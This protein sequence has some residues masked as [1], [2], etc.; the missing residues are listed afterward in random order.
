MELSHRQRRAMTILLGSDREVTLGVLAEA[1]DVSPRTVHR[2]LSRLGPALEPWGLTVRGRSGQGVQ[3]VG[4]PDRL[5]AFQEV[6]GG[7]PD[8]SLTAADR[9]WMAVTLLL[10]SS[11]SV[12]VFALEREL[13]VGTSAVR[14]ELDALE[15]WLAPFELALVRRRGFGVAVEGPE[16]QKRLALGA[17]LALRFSENDLMALFRDA[18]TRGESGAAEEFLFE[19]YP[20]AVVTR[21]DTLVDQASRNEAW[22]WAPSAGLALTLHLVTSLVRVGAGFRLDRVPAPRG[23]RS[24]ARRL[25]GSLAEAFGLIFPAPEVEWTA[26]HLEA[27]K[28]NRTPAGAQRTLAPDLVKGVADLVAAA[29]R[30]TGFPFDRD[31]VLSEGLTAH[32]GP[33]LARLAHRLPIA[34]ALLPEIHQRFP[35][36]IDA[37]GRAL[38][39][40]YPRLAVPPEEIGYL[41]LHFAAS[42]ERSHREDVPFRALIVCSSGIGTSHM[43]ASRIRAEVPEIEVV[44]ALS[45]FE[46]KNFSRERYDLLISTVPLPLAQEDYIVVSPLLD[47]AGLKTLRDHMRRQR[48]RLTAQPP[49]SR[50][51][52]SLGDLKAWNRSLGMLIALVED[53]KAF[54]GPA[55]PWWPVVAQR[56]AEAGWLTGPFSGPELPEPTGEAPVLVVPVTGAPRS[57]LSVH[58]LPS[59]GWVSLVV[60]PASGFEPGEAALAVLVDG[61]STPEARSATAS[62]QETELRAV[63]ARTLGRN[64]GPRTPQGD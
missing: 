42:V 17:A 44:A 55:T 32:W 60:Y 4:E 64:F 27:S 19:R 2:E 5:R 53:L 34:N 40:V 54:D 61:L 14:A 56:L 37:V 29:V 1:L 59:G 13:G 57:S 6:L 33:A 52:P 28:P 48:L 50:P 3:L 43:L 31:A 18:G 15:P 26:L 45:W 12:K 22:D 63:L 11:S 7:V 46:V 47:E 25:L 8:R 21:V 9:R 62:G 20:R 58:R 30:L 23:D 39:E 38:A 35:D 36:L 16:F 51:A 24:P 49:E 41:V 10:E